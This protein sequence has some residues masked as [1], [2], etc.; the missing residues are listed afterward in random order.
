MKGIPNIIDQFISTGWLRA[1]SSVLS[2][3]FLSL[4]LSCYSP[5]IAANDL[6]N[7]RQQLPAQFYEQQWQI[8][9]ADIELQLK[10]L[11][12]PT[13]AAATPKGQDPAQPSFSPTQWQALLDSLHLCGQLYNVKGA[14]HYRLCPNYLAA[15][16]I[17]REI[18]PS[19][20]F[21]SQPLP[22]NLRLNLPK[23]LCITH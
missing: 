7:E 5:L 1:S 16:Q 8:D 22:T 11:L 19:T 21:Q 15:A 3:T 12:A 17:L 23:A 20:L 10:R 9:C 18:D 6:A 14:P 2:F 13:Q 4:L